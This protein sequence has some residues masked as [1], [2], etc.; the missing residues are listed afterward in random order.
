MVIRLRSDNH[1]EKIVNECFCAGNFNNDGFDL[2][3]K[4][5]DET[6]CDKVFMKES[7]RNS[8]CIMCYESDM[9]MM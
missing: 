5:N 9:Y 4:L 3:D 7:M 6:Y 2:S 1:R 8:H